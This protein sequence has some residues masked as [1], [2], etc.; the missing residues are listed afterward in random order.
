MLFTFIPSQTW[1][2]SFFDYNCRL[3]EV[4]SKIDSTGP[5][6]GAPGTGGLSQGSNREIGA[7]TEGLDND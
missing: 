4:D 5:K 1:K 3:I 2:I 6:Y 7:R